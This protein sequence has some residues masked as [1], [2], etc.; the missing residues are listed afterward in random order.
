M[1]CKFPQFFSAFS[2]QRKFRER[3]LPVQY[4]QGSAFS[5]DF[6][7][8]PRTAIGP[9]IRARL[10]GKGHALTDAGILKAAPGQHRCPTGHR[11]AVMMAAFRFTERIPL[12][13]VKP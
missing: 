9:E 10:S 6:T 4:R 5:F 12:A 11:S 1:Q 8:T 2:F 13:S 7:G 3:Q